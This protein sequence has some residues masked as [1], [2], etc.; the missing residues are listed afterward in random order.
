[1]DGPLPKSRRE[2][3]FSAGTEVPAGPGGTDLYAG[4]VGTLLARGGQ[5]IHLHVG[6]A[7]HGAYRAH[8]RAVGPQRHAVLLLAGHLA[9][10][11]ANA[12]VQ[13]DHKTMFHTRTSGV[14]SVGCGSQGLKS[15]GLSHTPSGGPSAL[16]TFTRKP[17]RV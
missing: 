10:L 2:W 16:V 6:I 15:S 9:P 3:T 7:P 11:A 4:R 13:V 14:G 5:E 12:A 8:Q 17:R 1:M